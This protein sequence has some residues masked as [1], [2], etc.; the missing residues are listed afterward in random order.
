MISVKI[1]RDLP[2]VIEDSDYFAKFLP[3]AVQAGAFIIE[4]AYAREAPGHIGTYK[5]SI[6]VQKVGNGSTYIVKP[7]ARAKGFNY[8]L[9]LYTGTGRMRGKPDFGYTSGRVRAGDV[10]RGIGG[11][12]PNKVAKRVAENRKV[13]RDAY[14]KADQL[15]KQLLRKR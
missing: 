7:T 14:K 9:A 11:I 3:K 5:G 12:R 6:Q 13:Q 4:D 8:P 15:V 1:R 2:R 10:A